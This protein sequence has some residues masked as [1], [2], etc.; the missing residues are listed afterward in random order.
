MDVILATMS[1]GILL[2]NIA[3]RRSKELF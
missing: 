3:P 2:C 1:I